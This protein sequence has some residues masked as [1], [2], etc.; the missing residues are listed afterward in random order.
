MSLAKQDSLHGETAARRQV[1]APGAVAGAEQ[2]PRKML[3][4]RGSA[5]N[6]GAPVLCVSGRPVRSTLIQPTRAC[7]S[8]LH[9]HALC[10]MQVPLQKDLWRMGGLLCGAV[11]PLMGST[12]HS[13]LAL[14]VQG[15]TLTDP[16]T[17][18]YDKRTPL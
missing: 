17:A 2:N 1:L 10:R 4:L 16:G 3:R 13:P 9:V 6:H 18:D 14:S 8:S 11:L 12:N 5:G 7:P 15:L